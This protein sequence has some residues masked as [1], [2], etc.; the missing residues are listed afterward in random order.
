MIQEKVMTSGKERFSLITAKELLAV[1]KLIED[2]DGSRI[3]KMPL[4]KGSQFLRIKRETLEKMSQQG[5]G[6]EI[7]IVGEE[8]TVRLIGSDKRRRNAYRYLYI[9]LQVLKQ[10]E[11]NRVLK[12]LPSIPEILKE[13]IPQIEEIVNVA[14]AGYCDLPD[15]D[16]RPLQVYLGACWL[17]IKDQSNLPNPDNVLNSLAY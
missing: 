1:T 11:G 17:S 14:R 5:R 9:L 4:N 12:Y 8:M 7:G 6:L 15:E 2:N 13:E 16:L 10:G 3:V